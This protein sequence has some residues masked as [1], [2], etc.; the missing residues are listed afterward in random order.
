MDTNLLNQ[1]VS[2]LK[3]LGAITSI[4]VEKAFSKVL[5]HK[6]LETFCLPGDLKQPIE[7]K[8]NNPDSEHL[9]LIYSNNSLVTRIAMVSHQVQ[10]L[11]RC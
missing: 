2:E 1:M 10:H 3:E 6:F 4:Q 9:K 8:L 7:H 11:N 5:R